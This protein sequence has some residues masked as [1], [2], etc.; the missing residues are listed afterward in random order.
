[1]KYPDVVTEMMGKEHGRGKERCGNKNRPF[2]LL[3]IYGQEV[4]VIKTV[5]HFN[6]FRKY[7]GM[8]GNIADRSVGL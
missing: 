1:M 4:E 7:G 6:F 2:G 5:P 3:T 8:Q